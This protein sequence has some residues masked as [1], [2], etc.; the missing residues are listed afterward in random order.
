MMLIRKIVA[1][2]AA[3]VV[4]VACDDDDDDPIAP[5]P[6][7]FNVTLSRAAETPVCNT[8]GA[9]AA[10]SATVTINAAETSIT[11]SNLTFTGLSGPATLGHI[12]SGASGVPGPAVIDFGANPT[13]PFNG[14][15]TA[16]NYPSPV[17]AGAPANFDAFIDAMKAGNTYINIHTAACP[18]GEIRGQLVDNN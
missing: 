6:T 13:S 8:A 18:G 7:T 16:S 17:P 3:T 4:I 1:A 14:T 5:Q 10:G 12:H 15:F 2:L 9:T 11:V